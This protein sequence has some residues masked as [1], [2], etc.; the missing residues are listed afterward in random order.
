MRNYQQVPAQERLYRFMEGP[1]VGKMTQQQRDGWQNVSA[2]KN[3]SMGNRQLN[4]S[5]PSLNI[6]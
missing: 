1:Q 4:S 3:Q 2:E 6:H 5:S